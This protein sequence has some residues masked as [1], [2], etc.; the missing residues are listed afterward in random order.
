M[1]NHD[2]TVQMPILAVDYRINWEKRIYPAEIDACLAPLLFKL[3]K[4][5]IKTTH[6]C[7]RHGMPLQDNEGHITIEK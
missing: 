1:C 3:H 5:G 2:Q 6:S 4:Q 7:C